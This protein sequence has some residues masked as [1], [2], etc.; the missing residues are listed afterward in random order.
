M[1]MT[2]P[3]AS[4]PRPA[5]TSTGLSKHSHAASHAGL[6]VA[7]PRS[8]KALGIYLTWAETTQSAVITFPQPQVLQIGLWDI[9]RTEVLSSSQRVS[10]H[11]SSLQLWKTDQG[12]CQVLAHVTST[13]D[14]YHHA[15]STVQKRQHFPW[16]LD[17]ALSHLLHFGLQ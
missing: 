14:H 8:P 16:I 10:I 17:K 4:T 9:R 15:L 12:L 3:K 5:H 1:S 7:E 6:G 13:T 11:P 2:C